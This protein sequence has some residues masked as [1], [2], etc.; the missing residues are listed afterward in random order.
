ME[1]TAEKKIGRWIYNPKT[2][3]ANCSECGGEC[4]HDRYGRIETED[5]P[6]CGAKLREAV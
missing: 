5:C 2:D 3:L 1:D 4:P 6:H